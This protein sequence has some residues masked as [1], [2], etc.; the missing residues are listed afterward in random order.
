MKEVDWILVLLN[1]CYDNLLPLADFETL[2]KNCFAK[3]IC[4]NL[5]SLYF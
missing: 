2:K 5:A 3:N 4:L 1:G